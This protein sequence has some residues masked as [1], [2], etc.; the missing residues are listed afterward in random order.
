MFD[1]V[2]LDDTS[3][4]ILPF[5]VMV[6]SPVPTAYTSYSTNCMDTDDATMVAIIGFTCSSALQQNYCE[7]YF[8]PTCAGQGLC[9]RLC[10]ELLGFCPVGEG[11]ADKS[12]AF[13]DAIGVPS[14]PNCQEYFDYADGNKD[15]GCTHLF[16]PSCTSGL[17]LNNFCDASSGFCD[18]TPVPTVYV[19]GPWGASCF[20]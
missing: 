10:G 4:H 3:V 5:D 15:Y 11:C 6:P 13:F 16:C 9:D 19:P 8:C 17:A 14:L 18:S 2:A 20:M 12:D 7:L 1:E